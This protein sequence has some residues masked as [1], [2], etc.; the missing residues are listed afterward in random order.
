M[1]KVS[2]I[3]I[4][5]FTVVLGIKNFITYNESIFVFLIFVYGFF[6]LVTIG[7][8]TSLSSKHYV[9]N[10]ITQSR[11]K[12]NMFLVYTI[13]LIII[14]IYAKIFFDVTIKNIPII[15]IFQ[16]IILGMI[17]SSH[18]MFLFFRT[19]RRKHSEKEFNIE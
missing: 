9:E 15:N 3:F 2:V 12:E 18:I 8:C 19:L 17:C 10:Q 1:G 16:F 13:L 14:L 6:V 11:K 7:I 4:S 5:V